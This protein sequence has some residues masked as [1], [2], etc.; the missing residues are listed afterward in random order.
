MLRPFPLRTFDEIAALG[1]E[2]E[3]YCA[4]CYR[5]VGPIDLTDVRLKGRCFAGA[6]FVCSRIRRRF[7][8]TPAERC[9][10]LGALYIR[11]RPGDRIPPRAA[12]PWCSIACPRCVPYWEVE[13]AAR[14]LPPWDQAL[15]GADVRLACPACRSALTTAW[16]GLEGVPHT[17]GYRCPIPPPS[18]PATGP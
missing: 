11:P 7:D 3:V 8:A 17:D 16:S 5:H 13:Q 12:R 15:K 10:S 14:H 1:L 6:R 2:V 9:G 18:T 4:S